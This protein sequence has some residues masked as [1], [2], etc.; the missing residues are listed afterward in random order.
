[1]VKDGIVQKEL[2]DETEMQTI[3]ST[4]RPANRRITSAIAA[5]SILKSLDD[6]DSKDAYRRSVLQG[7]VDG[8]SPYDQEML[9]EQ[10]LDN[11]IN[12]NFM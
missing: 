6:E 8:N 3:T 12:V 1:M 11:M 10:G 5:R 7:M 4:G 2:F 9:K